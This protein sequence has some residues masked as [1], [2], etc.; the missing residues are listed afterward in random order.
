MDRPKLPY[1]DALMKEALRWNP[2]L[3][4]GVPHAATQDDEY[5]GW[6]IPKGAIIFPNAWGMLRDERVYSDP[7]TFQPER[8]LATEEKPSELDPT[9]SG[10]FGFGKR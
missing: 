1:M 8:F 9:A 7:Y 10:V 4:I 5:R 2:A 3:P 6:K